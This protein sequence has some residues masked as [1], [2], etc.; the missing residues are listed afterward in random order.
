[1]T[2]VIVGAG[3]AGVTAAETLRK[4]DP[5]GEVVLIGAEDEP[6]YSRMAIPYLLT[7]NDRRGRNLSAQDRRSLRCQRASSTCA[8]R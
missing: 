7:G 3:P 8:K 1:M 2:Y 6:P 5:E 4:A